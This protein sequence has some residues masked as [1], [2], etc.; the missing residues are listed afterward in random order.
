MGKG[1]A[2]TRTL[3]PV[4]VLALAF[5]AGAGLRLAG[6]PLPAA[7]LMVAAL[8][9]PIQ[10]W[11]RPTDRLP[12][13]V[14]LLACSLAGW[15]HVAAAQARV[16]RD[17]R[18]VLPAD[19]LTA[20]GTVTTL[21][22]AGRAR[23]RVDSLTGGPVQ[24]RREIR[25]ALPR[26]SS[27]VAVGARIGVRG[28]WSPSGGPGGDPARAGIVLASSLRRQGSHVP[29][30]RRAGDR[31]AAAAARL[32]GAAAAALD[33][34]LG[35]EAA[36]AK[37]LI[38]ARRDGLDPG[39]REA[40]VR[41]GT[42]HLLAISGFH[43]G[44]LALLAVTLARAAGATLGVAGCVGAG[45]AWSYVALLGFPD[46]ATRAAL[47][48]ALVAS[49]R[50][51]GRPVLG[52]GV[53]ATALLCFA[54]LD[55]LALGRV[56]FQLSFAGAFGLVMGARPVAAW[57]RQQT[58]Q[59][60]R[61]SGLRWLRGIPSVV[62]EGVAAS[63][64]ATAFTLPLV[65]WHFEAV[66]LVGIPATL[67]AGPLVAA[68]L[69]GLLLVVALGLT[70]S[71]AAAL[72]AAGAGALLAAA[73]WVVFVLASFRWAAVPVTRPQVLAASVGATLAWLLL[74]SARGVGRPVRVAA[75]AAGCAAA[76]VVAPLADAAIR[77]GS[78]ELHILDVGQGDAIA[79][80][81]PGGRWLLVDTGPDPGDRVVRE[82]RRLGVSRVA[83]LVLT[84]PDLDHLGGAAE[85]LDAFQVPEIG[86][87]GTA[88]G[89]G[90]YLEVLEAAAEEPA[91]WRILVRGDR[92][93]LDGVEVAVLHPGP[94]PPDAADAAQSPN[95]RSVVL[96]VSWHGF[97]ALLT[98]DAPL[99]AEAEFAPLTGVVDLLKVGHHGSR[100]STGAALLAA[101]QP[102]VAV[103]SVGRYNRFGH[104]S[105]AVLRRLRDNGVRVYRTDRA[106]S[107]HVRV[108]PSGRWEVHGDR[109]SGD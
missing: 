106:G 87:P 70:G 3:P 50:L 56:G 104:P 41:S 90:P 4:T 10:P 62:V 14:G 46:A 75:V 9:L 88:R 40:F 38:L 16:R 93:V 28:L 6:A 95:D 11:T 86:D 21:E 72:P 59:W 27:P 49:G 82:L 80:R 105:P 91:R 44:V 99:A 71:A 34:H 8:A 67:L 7:P 84:H 37:A 73:R 78:M 48:V 60:A 54:L 32:R 100:T 2:L 92:L 52:A 51:L 89:S 98:G 107:V 102:E 53:L 81:T 103:I 22:A 68:A 20:W 77:D 83:L 61:R 96:R 57:I 26:R 19:S 17:C 43:V 29:G 13:L 47:L 76:L 79:L 55:P 74:R 31:V 5:V 12:V 108:E 33:R 36:L 85:I 35:S 64:A 58:G 39:V 97:R 24:C 1:R 69:P 18:W 94:V 101:T 109:P 63:A 23:L 30:P 42:A 15:L 25:V 45:V 66:S 65:A